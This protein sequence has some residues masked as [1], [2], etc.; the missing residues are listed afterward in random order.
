MGVTP[1]SGLVE[2][3]GPPA[4]DGGFLAEVAALTGRRYPCKVADVLA[5]V[6]ADLRPDVVEALEDHTW[7]SRAVAGALTNRGF[8]IGDTTI[9][10]H[11]NGQ[12][13]CE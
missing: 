11:R 5:A 10:R 3:T 13:A 6:P 8:R 1:D 12:C 7:S 2:V 9:K 4:E